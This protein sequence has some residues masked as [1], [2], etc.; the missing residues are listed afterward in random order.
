MNC[1][2]QSTCIMNSTSVISIVLQQSVQCQYD[3]HG[4]LYND[5]ERVF[6]IFSISNSADTERYSLVRYSGGNTARTFQIHLIKI[7]KWRGNS[8]THFYSL[9]DLAVL[10]LD[11]K[12]CS[13][14]VEMQLR[15]PSTMPELFFVETFTLAPILRVSPA[16]LLNSLLTFFNSSTILVLRA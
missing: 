1:T 12:M 15:V 7:H 13:G 11:K 14:L 10:F 4:R 9:E 6:S 3:Q 2:L 8:S 16:M 5:F